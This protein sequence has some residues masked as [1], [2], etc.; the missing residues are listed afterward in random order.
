[1]KINNK[2]DHVL[3]D[4]L[5]KPIEIGRCYEIPNWN[6]TTTGGYVSGLATIISINCIIESNDYN[7]FCFADVEFMVDG[8]IFHRDV[9]DKDLHS[10]SR[11]PNR[12]K[13]KS[14]NEKSTN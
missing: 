3:V 13:R 14:K 12:P 11:K 2:K 10:L 1:M 7:A 4:N 8:V 9:F 5:S 6:H